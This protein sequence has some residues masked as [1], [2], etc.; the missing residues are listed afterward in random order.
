M[1][2]LSPLEQ[3]IQRNLLLSVTAKPHHD[4]PP[5]SCRSR[6]KI[7]EHHFVHKFCHWK[8]LL[9]TPHFVS[10]SLLDGVSTGE[11]TK[12]EAVPL[13]DAPPPPRPASRSPG[14]VLWGQRFF[15]GVKVVTRT[16]DVAEG[17]LETAAVSA[18]RGTVGVSTGPQ[19][20][21]PSQGAVPG[22][23]RAPNS[24]RL[25]PRTQ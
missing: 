18:S 10:R 8:C 7:S 12:E 4:R 2:L 13:A 15:L 16:C 20:E 25:Q 14:R 22:R 1:S 9:K 3:M 19:R 11:S 23:G 6:C 21:A 17:R 5:E 24:S